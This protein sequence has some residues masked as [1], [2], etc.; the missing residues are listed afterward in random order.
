[1]NKLRGVLNLGLLAGVFTGQT[2][3]VSASAN[4]S[5][6]GVP[7]GRGAERR[8]VCIREMPSSEGVWK[9]GVNLSSIGYLAFGIALSNDVV[10]CDDERRAWVWLKE[11]PHQP[12]L[13]AVALD[14]FVKRIEENSASWD[15]R[16]GE[17]ERSCLTLDKDRTFFGFIDPPFRDFENVSEEDLENGNFD[18]APNKDEIAFLFE[19]CGSEYVAIV[20]ASRVVNAAP[21]LIEPS[22]RLIEFPICDAAPCEGAPERR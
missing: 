22:R 20:T 7:A 3:A 11:F 6:A 1:M 12:Y 9:P 15:D 10:K 21:V 17:S 5:D 13:L 19:S 16:I 8:P 14:T 18:G 4:E 2:T